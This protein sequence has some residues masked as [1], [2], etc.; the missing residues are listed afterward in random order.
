DVQAWEYQPLGPFLAKN[1]LTT[2]S[3]W[4]VTLEAL[5]P[6]RLP[7]TRPAGEPPPLAYLD[8]AG[9]R[10]AGAIDLHLEVHLETARMRAA[11]APPQR[12]SH[13]NFRDAWWTVAHMLTHHS[14]NGCNLRPGDLLGSGTQSGPQPEEAGSLLELSA[15]GRQPLA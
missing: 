3:P 8:D 5:A 12:L 15:G 14:V 10:E 4:V 2:V 9:V 1:F 11:G 7:W 13:S 6:Y